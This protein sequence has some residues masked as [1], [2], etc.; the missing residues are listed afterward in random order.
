MNLGQ[1]AE[2]K[3]ISENLKSGMIDYIEPGETEYTEKDV[4]AC[5][6]LLNNFLD[7]ISESDSKKQGMLCVKK[8]VLALNDLNEKCEYE[9]IETDQRE[10]IA[11]III[12]GGY[13]RG[14]NARREDITEDWREW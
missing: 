6:T 2:I 7:E 9:L 10:Q 8:V 4:E 1:N 13:V 14:Y 5:M 11:E 3:K 12:L